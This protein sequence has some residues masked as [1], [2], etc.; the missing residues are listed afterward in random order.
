MKINIYTDGASRGNP[1]EAGI[2]F[3]LVNEKGKVIKEFSSFVGIRT[4]NAA[5]YM[6]LIKALEEAKKL[7]ATE[8]TVFSD[9]ELMV[10]QLNLE[11]KVKNEGLKPLYDEVQKLKNAFKSA[12][13]IHIPRSQNKRADELANYGIDSKETEERRIKNMAILQITVIPIATPTTSLSN[14]VTECQ[15]ILKNIEGIKYQLTPMSTIVEGDLDKIFEVAKKLHEAPFEK[16][17]ERVITSFAIDDRRDKPL[18]ME[19][20]VK[21]VEEKL[22]N[23]D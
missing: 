15:R 13:F 21:S 7:K 5:E 8:V 18:T 6:A 12:S 4:N 9:S 11:Y 22:K 2:G 10:K 17:I 23:L 14:Y 1:G 16:G 3:V 20:K 19:G